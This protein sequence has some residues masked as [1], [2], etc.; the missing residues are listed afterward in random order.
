MANIANI[1]FLSNAVVDG[2]SGNDTI[3]GND[4]A[5][6]RNDI[7]YGHQ[8][9]DTI[10]TLH[11]L[12]NST[13]YGGQGNDT[14]SADF[15]AANVI[16]GN[17]GNDFITTFADSSSTLY[18]GQGNDTIESSASNAEVI[19]GNQENDLL[20]GNDGTSNTHEYGGQGNDTLVFT[21]TGGGITFNDIETGNLG[22]DLFIATNDS[23]VVVSNG[24]GLPLNANDIVTVTDFLQ[25]SD[26]LS[27]SHLGNIPL[28]KIAGI[29]DNAQ[30]ALNDANTFYGNAPFTGEY[31]FVYGGTGAG[32]LF[33]NGD[34][35]GKFA[36]SGM[37]VL[38]ANGQ[39]SV[40]ASDITTIP[41]F[42]PA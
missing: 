18:G 3:L 35:G 31:V 21:G 20:F 19:Y 39:N 36:A 23:S 14:L 15:S 10:S 38:G 41:N 17:L 7:V 33:Y 40:M 34:D 4:P 30:Q 25:G 42:I 16:Y 24:A 2:S 5:G 27:E 12:F 32:Y 11:G 9:D 8:G 1:T 6:N 28:V 37:A 13:V 26:Q 22:N 29:G